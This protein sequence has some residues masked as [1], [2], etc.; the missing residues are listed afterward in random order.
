MS[1]ARENLT[2]TKSLYQLFNERKLDEAVKHVAND[3]V[4]NST[5]TGEVFRGPAGC[6]EF[7]QRWITA[8]S[9]SRVDIKN[10]IATDDYVVTEFIGRGTHDGSL[11]TPQGMVPATHRKMELSFCEVLEIKNGKV[12]S[13]NLYFDSATMMRQLGLLP[14]HAEHR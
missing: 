1:N 8:F 11:K 9:N 3:G 5:P 2:L 10:Q 7:L 6:K 14:E 4:W 13:A 12:S